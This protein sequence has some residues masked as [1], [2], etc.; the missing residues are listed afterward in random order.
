[1]TANISPEEKASAREEARRYS[2]L[3]HFYAHRMNRPILVITGGLIGTGK[4]TIAGSWRRALGWEWPEGG[5]LRRNWPRSL[6]A[7]IVLKPLNRESILLIFRAG[8]TKPSLTGRESFWA[9]VKRPFS[10]GSF[11]KQADR[12]RPLLAVARETRRRFSADRKCQCADGRDSERLARRA[13]R[14]NE[15]SDGRWEI[16]R[17][18]EERL[19]SAWKGSNADLHLSLD[20]ATSASWSAW[21]HPPAPPPKSGTWELFGARWH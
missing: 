5:P 3:S 10:D 13:S 12:R 14:R 17:G 21:N 2:S 8:P 4:S 20:T 18:S 16:F 15:L 6:P 11:K 1:M 19:R 7:S 9:R